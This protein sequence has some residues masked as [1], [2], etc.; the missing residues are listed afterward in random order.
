[1]VVH[2]RSHVAA[3]DV[4]Q[5]A[6]LKLRQLHQKLRQAVISRHPLLKDVPVPLRAA[7]YS[8]SAVSHANRYVYVRVPKAANSTVS[9]TLAWLSY[10]DRR[11]VISEDEEGHAAKRLFSRYPWHWRT[12]EALGDY[13]TFV[14]V[15]DPFSRVLSAYLD[16]IAKPGDRLA[17]RFV[18]KALGKPLT[19]VS[20][21]DFVAFL[22]S[23]GLHGNI[24]WA[25][26][27]DICPLPLDRID[28][29]GKVETI[30]SD[31][32]RIGREVFGVSEVTTQQRQTGRTN[33]TDRMAAFYDADLT[34]RVATLYRRDL[35]AFGYDAD[36][37]A[38]LSS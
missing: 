23:G 9:K 17:Y 16:K 33:S 35:E 32:N 3:A 11:N 36:L 6:D 15:R 24:H 1:M 37:R 28:L 20:F 18:A 8:R 25:P 4:T 26:Q 12:P 5:E 27:V 34:A 22:E 38:R 21:A 31:L 13:F 10:P 19:D 29:I 30:D 14:F 2:C 7:V